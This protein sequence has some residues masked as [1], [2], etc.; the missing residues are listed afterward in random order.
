MTASSDRDAVAGT[1]EGG[2]FDRRGSRRSRKFRRSDRGADNCSEARRRHLLSYTPNAMAATRSIAVVALIVQLAVCQNLFDVLS[3]SKQFETFAATAVSAG[4]DGALNAPQ[5]F[6]VFAPTD[7]A[8]DALPQDLADKLLD[9][10]GLWLPQLQDLMFYHVIEGKIYTSDLT[11]GS[12]AESLNF[13]GD[14]I[15]LTE[16]LVNSKNF[17]VEADNGVLHAIDKGMASREQHNLAQVAHPDF[18][19]LLLQF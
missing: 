2:G 17:D 6:T 16:V 15:S 18:S 5:S 11:D 1:G 14:S 12:K 4:L 19:S 7:D 10:D 8:F 13:A 3:R 9:S